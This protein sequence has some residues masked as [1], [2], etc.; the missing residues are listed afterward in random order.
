MHIFGEDY[1][2]T[3]EHWKELGPLMHEAM[4]VKAH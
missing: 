2:E 3:D 1:I 4:L